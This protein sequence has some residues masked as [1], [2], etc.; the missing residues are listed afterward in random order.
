MSKSRDG[1][2]FSLELKQEVRLYDLAAGEGRLYRLSY[3]NRWLAPV[4]ITEDGESAIF[5]Y[6]LEGLEPLDRLR[7]RTLS[8][9]LRF[10]VN[11]AGLESLTTEY[12]FS[13]KPDN[14]YIDHNLNPQIIMRDLHSENN[15]HD[16][17]QEYIALA[18]TLL[19]PKYSFEDYLE[20]GS[21]LCKKNSRTKDFPTAETTLEIL[22][23][24]KKQYAREEEIIRTQKVMVDRRQRRFLRIAA[25][26]CFALFLIGAGLTFYMSQIVLAQETALLT[27]SRA[28][29]REDFDGAIDA[30]HRV[31]PAN[32]GRE[33]RYQLA[34]AYIIAES[35]SPAQ[36]THILSGI[37]LM[38]DDNILLYWI[39]VGRM[40]FLDAIDIAMRVGDDEL[41]LFALV[42]Y[43]V[44]IQLDTTMTG[45][46][47][48]ALLS[49]INRQIEGLSRNQEER[50]T[51]LEEAELAELLAEEEAGETDDT[52]A[53]APE[54][55]G[56][57]Q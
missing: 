29:L 15:K 50:R 23:N 7:K 40:E 21:G 27:A 11:I 48:T 8:D 31:D 13:L 43:E 20:G 53:E 16:F 36:R 3:P 49:D 30:L 26:V 37:T 19:A 39:S 24:L 51:A 22:N 44:A 47:K 28:F 35:L 52:E 54:G 56:E 45:E 32:M 4:E 41:L 5:A 12:S 18:A 38:T 46:E 2:V 34:R 14:L 55:E 9:R 10:L 6:K 42:G 33:E 17:V 1:R 25:P 57:S